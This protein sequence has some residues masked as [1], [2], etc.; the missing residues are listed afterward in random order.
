MLHPITIEAAGGEY[1]DS[2]VIVEWT[3]KPGEK[4]TTGD[5]VVVVETAKAA[6]EVPAPHDGY[7][8]ETFFAPGEEAPVG[9]LLG[10]IGETP[11]AAGSGDSGGAPARPVAAPSETVSALAPASTSS[12]AP[13]PHG[14][15]VATPLARRIARAGGIDLRTVKGSGPG[16]RIKRRDV[17]AVAKARPSADASPA[18]G[19]RPTAAATVVF[20][21]GFGADRAAWRLVAPLLD[22]GVRVVMPELPGHGSAPALEVSRIDDIA[23]AIDDELAAQGVEEAHL[24]GHS[25]GGA[26][27]L[28]LSQIGRVRIRSLCLIAPGGLGPEIN[29]A[30]LN[31][32]TQATREDSLRPWLEKMVA[33]PARLPDGF[34]GTLLRQRERSGTQAAQARLLEALFPD[35]TQGMRLGAALDAVRVPAKVL[36]GTKDAVIPCSHASAVPGTVALHLLRDVGHVPQLECPEIVARLIGELIRSNP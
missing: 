1:M 14:R 4:V 3:V 34:A 5:T 16:G 15:T 20:L 21:H 12:A 24:V 30:F 9:A 27:A 13:S 10:N 29:S 8:V 18:V 11:E 17:E 32:F 36:W 26:A 28:A 23:R 25:L 33:D 35:G 2:V 7:L 6:T 31:G 22:P 19:V